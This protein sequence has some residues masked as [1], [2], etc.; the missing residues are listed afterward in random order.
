MLP[1]PSVRRQAPRFVY[2]E[3]HRHEQYQEATGSVNRE[4]DPHRLEIGT[5]QDRF[6][7]QARCVANELQ[8][9]QQDDSG[10]DGQQKLRQDPIVPEQAPRST[11]RLDKPGKKWSERQRHDDEPGSQVHCQ[12]GGADDLRVLAGQGRD[13]ESQESSN[14]AQ[15]ADRRGNMRSESEFSQSGCHGDGRGRRFLTGCDDMFMLSSS[16]HT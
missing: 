10:K 8:F 5:R 9:C 6:R 1:T 3:R 7:S 4:L 16:P 14:R 15:Q 2:W 12:I 13:G 11:E